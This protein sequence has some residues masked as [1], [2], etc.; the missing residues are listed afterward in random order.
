M[1]TATRNPTQRISS[2]PMA[3]VVAALPWLHLLALGALVIRGVIPVGGL[4]EP[5][6]PDPETLGAFHPIATYSQFA[7]F[8]AVPVLAAVALLS[9]IRRHLFWHRTIWAGI[10]LAIVIALGFIDPWE[11]WTWAELPLGPF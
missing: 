3:G 4:P 8:L 9:P 10:G 1:A 2:S 5:G 6:N 7:A 11:L